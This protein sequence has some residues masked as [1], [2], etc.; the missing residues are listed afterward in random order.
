MRNC[1][2]ALSLAVGF[3]VAAAST[4][5][6]KQFVTSGKIAAAPVVTF[7]WVGAMGCCCCFCFATNSAPPSP[8]KNQNTTTTHIHTTPT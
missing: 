7:L 6:G 8:P 3:I 2:V 4:Y 1:A 5:E